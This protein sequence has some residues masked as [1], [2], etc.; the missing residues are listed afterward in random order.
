MPE[1]WKE[2]WHLDKRVNLSII[3]VLVGQIAGFSWFIGALQNQVD[4]NTEM[5]DALQD[6]AAVQN[7]QLSRIEEQ[8][9]GLR[10]DIGRLI[11]K[12]DEK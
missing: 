2:G 10:R 7:S 6:Q 1:K 11:E 12:L 4:Q 5:I 8:I 9:V 3:F